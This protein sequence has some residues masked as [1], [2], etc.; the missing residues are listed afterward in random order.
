MAFSCGHPRGPQSWA[1]RSQIPG[2]GA[3]LGELG[4]LSPSPL[5]RMTRFRGLRA[6]PTVPSV[7]AV[8]RDLALA[9]LLP[10]CTTRN[11]EDSCHCLDCWA[12]PFLSGWTLQGYGQPRAESQQACH[13][14]V[15]RCCGARSSAQCPRYQESETWPFPWAR[16]SGRRHVV[17]GP[18]KGWAA[19]TGTRLR[20][21]QLKAAS[22]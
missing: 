2:F 6:P 1:S 19:P 14:N 11:W 8:P 16:R 5:L 18:S 13:P 3:A 9:S 7:R 20:E 10:S 12:L 15:G 4:Q 22:P 21:W 17:T